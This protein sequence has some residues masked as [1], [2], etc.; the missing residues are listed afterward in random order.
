ME[1]QRAGNAP[2][3]SHIR[4]P[5]PPR[6]PT[7]PICP[8]GFWS[9][10]SVTNSRAYSSVRSNRVGRISR[11]PIDVERSNRRTRC[12]IIERRIAAAGARSLLFLYGSPFR[13]LCAD[14]VMLGHMRGRNAPPSPSARE[15]FRDGTGEAPSIVFLYRVPGTSICG[16]PGIPLL[17][18]ANAAASVLEG[19]NR[20][21]TRGG[22]GGR[23]S[24]HV[25]GLLLSLFAGT[26]TTFTL[27]S[28]SA[29][30][31]ASLVK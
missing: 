17:C 20:G 29:C 4:S 6:I 28:T 12:R 22:I 24:T 9:N 19:G 25:L 1:C 15:Q 23:G 8:S 27:R 14:A 30:C 11:S 31:E 18:S 10:H 16:L 26:R 3:I 21:I 13:Q 5:I 2:D 7:I